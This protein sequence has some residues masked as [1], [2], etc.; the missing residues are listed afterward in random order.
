MVALAGAVAP[1]RVVVVVAIAARPAAAQLT[2]AGC[3][4]LAADALADVLAAAAAAAAAAGAAEQM[5]AARAEAQRGT[6]P[7]WLVLGQGGMDRD[8]G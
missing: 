8:G 1:A 5:R 7:G 6:M 4:V 3:A 2:P